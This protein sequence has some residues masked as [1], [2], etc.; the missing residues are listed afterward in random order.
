MQ[1]SA[2]ANISSLSGSSEFSSLPFQKRLLRP[3]LSRPVWISAE[4]VETDVAST[5]SGT[6][7]RIRFVVHLRIAL[8]VNLLDGVLGYST[9]HP[10]L[11]KRGYQTRPPTR[12]VTGW[13]FWCVRMGAQLPEGYACPNVVV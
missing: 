11:P 7:D 2:I 5:E 1:N 8:E 12:I 4:V 3:T 13:K 6:I 10:T 9:F